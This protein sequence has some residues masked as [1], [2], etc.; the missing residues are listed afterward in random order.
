MGETQEIEEVKSDL[1]SVLSLIHATNP[2]FR[3]DR[4][5]YCFLLGD[6]LQEG[7]AGF[8]KTA[9]EAAGG[10]CRLKTVATQTERSSS[11]SGSKIISSGSGSS[12]SGSGT[13]MIGSS[14]T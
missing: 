5:M 4:N 2:E 6:N 9:W 7:I 1:R 12:G 11:H 10:L 3:K 13:N 8:G 14:G